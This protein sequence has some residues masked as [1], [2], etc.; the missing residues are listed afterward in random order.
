[1]WSLGP[2]THKIAPSDACGLYEH[3]ADLLQGACEVFGR[4]FPNCKR[5]NGESEGDPTCARSQGWP[6]RGC[7][8]ESGV[9]AQGAPEGRGLAAF[10]C[11][12]REPEEA[13]PRL[14]ETDPG[15]Q[16]CVAGPGE[17][18]VL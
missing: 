4:Q 12:V 9:R 5:G 6:G 16:P 18:P 11:K 2:R 3:L 15:P 14:T 1:M 7:T 8:S 13:S 17:A 10:P